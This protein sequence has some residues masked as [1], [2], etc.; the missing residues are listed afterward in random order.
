MLAWMSLPRVL[1]DL[2]RATVLS[3][4]QVAVEANDILD[5]GDLVVYIDQTLKAGGS[6]SDPANSFDSESD[7]EDNIDPKAALAASAKN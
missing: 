3:C 4:L 2:L 1:I 7:G 6:P 5:A